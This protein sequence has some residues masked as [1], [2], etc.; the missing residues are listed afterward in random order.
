MKF[1]I[2]CLMLVFALTPAM[3]QD[4]IK[5]RGPAPDF[6]T[7]GKWIG[8]TKPLTLERLRGK[9]V[10][11]HFWR[12][13]DEACESNFKVFESWLAKHAPAGLTVIGIHPP[14]FENNPEPAE[15]EKTA[16]KYAKVF[17]SLIEETDFTVKGW[18][19]N[20]YPTLFLIDR[21][22]Q[23]RA[24]FEGQLIYKRFRGDLVVEKFIDELL[25]EK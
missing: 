8:T 3:A 14:D 5:K 1:V 12:H 10:L 25:S 18:N 11:V 7:A 22:G 23:F 4:L 20:G 13:G 16:V 2:S 6:P 24:A 9:V 15:V 19:V 21:R 17:P